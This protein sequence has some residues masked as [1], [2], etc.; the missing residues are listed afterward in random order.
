MVGLVLHVP[1]LA[2]SRA[3]R[4][5]LVDSNDLTMDLPSDWENHPHMAL[6]RVV[7]EREGVKVES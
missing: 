6:V 7:A 4:H 3:T 5:G 1:V 2:L